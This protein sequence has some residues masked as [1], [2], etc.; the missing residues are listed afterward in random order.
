FIYKSL[1]LSEVP[2]LTSFDLSLGLYFDDPDIDAWFKTVANRSVSELRINSF[3]RNFALPSCLSACG[4]LKTLVLHQV[5]LLG[6]QPSF[7]LH[8]LK[9]LH[10]LSVE[11][12]GGES[13]KTFL[14]V[15]PILEVLVV[16][17]GA[18][19]NITDFS[20]FLKLEP[21]PDLVKA[22]IDTTF[23]QPE[24]FMESLTS[25]RHLS[26]CCNSNKSLYPSHGTFFLRLE[27]LELCTCTLT[28]CKTLMH[29]LNHGPRLRV[30]KLKRFY[31][32][33]HYNG[34]KELDNW[35][36]KPSSVPGCLS[37]H[38]EIFEWRYYQGTE[39]ERKMTKYI[40]ANASRLKMATFASNSAEKY[41]MFKNIN[42][43]SFPIASKACKLVCF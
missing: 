14:N 38:L 3:S 36:T 23:D 30:L 19:D 13:V 43:A 39:Q 27:H 25:V 37:S 31:H 2:V 35:W 20:R 10:L 32:L 5:R 33:H 21:M 40:L 42:I 12:R 22:N 34:Y 17:R 41:Q 15:C 29:L 16:R 9:N 1:S 6:L 18:C 26:L 4:T 11:F 28:W 8:S 24:S 7:C